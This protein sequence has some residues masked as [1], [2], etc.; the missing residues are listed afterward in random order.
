VKERLLAP[1]QSVKSNQSS[2][3]DKPSQSEKSTVSQ[4]QP[5]VTDEH[6]FSSNHEL[7]LAL[8]TIGVAGLVWY[9]FK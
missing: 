9:L 7:N 1:S 6:G 3:K 2:Q 5:D 8:I 4:T